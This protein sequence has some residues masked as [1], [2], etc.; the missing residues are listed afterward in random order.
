MQRMIEWGLVHTKDRKA[1]LSIEELGGG[2][3]VKQVTRKVWVQMS[4]LPSEL[5]DFLTIWAVGT[6]LGVTKDVD[7]SFTRQHNRA[8]MQV[9]V[10]DLALIP[11]SVDV[12]IG[13]NVYEMFFKVEPEEMGDKPL[14][15]EMDDGE[16][17]EDKTD[18]ANGGDSELGNHMQEDKVSDPKNNG[19]GRTL[20]PNMSGQN[21]GFKAVAV[22]HI[23]LEESVGDED[24]MLF[25]GEDFDAMDML[26]NGISPDDEVQEAL[27]VSVVRPAKDAAAQQ[28]MAAIPAADTPSRKS[29]RRADSVDEHS[30]ERAERMKAACNLDLSAGKGTKTRP[31]SSFIHFSNEHVVD[32]IR[33]VGISLGENEEQIRSL[34]NKIKEVELGRHLDVNT[35]D[36]TC[37]AFDKEEKE[38]LEREEGDKLILNSLCAELM[39]E[40]ID[41]GNAYLPNC[42]ITPR[43]KNIF[44]VK[45]DKNSRSKGKKKS[46]K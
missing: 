3:N 36:A 8:K 19:S 35:L 20:V 25:D 44:L 4:R 24:G 41:L 39:D 46:S 18:E 9:S 34:V 6:I 2:S 12:V 27:D 21:G 37:E 14:L 5:R 26:E 13:D 38:E 45:K 43:Q 23:A 40:V 29:K 11:I 7:M 22:D 28:E 32:N 10:L 1:V 16:D 17:E 30:L 31:N 33:G 42:N 15:L